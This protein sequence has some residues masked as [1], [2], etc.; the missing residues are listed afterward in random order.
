MAE[1]AA[2]SEAE[3]EALVAESAHLCSD[4]SD[5]AVLDATRQ[6]STDVDAAVFDSAVA[7]CAENPG[8]TWSETITE[9]ELEA[10][11][12]SR[13]DQTFSV[14]DAEGYTF[15][16]V[17]NFG[18]VGVTADP[19]SQSPGFTA[20]TREMS[21]G[22]AIEN[23]TSQRDLMFEEVSGI[24]SPLDLPTF[25]FSAAFNAGN[26]VC[27]LVFESDEDCE[28]ALGFGRMENGQTVAAG[29]RYV[30]EAW[31]GKPN[32]GDASILLQNIPEAAWDQVQSHLSSPD[33]YRITYSG[34]DHRRFTSVCGESSMVPVLVQTSAC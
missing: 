24:V 29:R 2:I 26:P 3:E 19:S 12:I 32:G 14:T 1:D 7:A 15:D 27:T 30:L 21:L 11:Y 5:A 17:V 25:L 18:L 23:T 9:A 4:L 34:G 28:W 6:L 33:G 16:L 31:S 22:M 13:L 20:A 8:A 10:S